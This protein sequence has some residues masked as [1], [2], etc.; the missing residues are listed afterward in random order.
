MFESIIKPVDD[1]IKRSKQKLENNP[2]LEQL[3]APIQE[4]LDFYDLQIKIKNQRSEQLGMQGKLEE[5]EEEQAQIERF[6][7]LKEE[8][9]LTLENPLSNSKAMRICE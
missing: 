9:I 2:M 5:L 1:K 8:T 7:K 3:P 4:K 6:K